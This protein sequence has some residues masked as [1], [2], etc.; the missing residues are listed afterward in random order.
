MKAT[1]PVSLRTVDSDM[2]DSPLPSRERLNGDW[3]SAARGPALVLIADDDPMILLLAQQALDPKSFTVVTAENGR[4]A[5]DRFAENTPDLVLCD[6]MMPDINGFDLC[7]SIR[8][9]PPGEHV[10][11][12]MLSPKG[13]PSVMGSVDFSTSL[14]LGPVAT[15]SSAESNPKAFLV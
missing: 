1:Q 8:S 2:P 12:I 14:R 7:K 6:V 5:L 4:Q 3:R 9:K 10:P 15:M 13:A 11:V